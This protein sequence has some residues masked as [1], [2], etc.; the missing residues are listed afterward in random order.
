LKEPLKRRERALK[1]SD[2][3]SEMLMFLFEKIRKKKYILILSFLALI[4]I[5]YFEFKIPQIT[6]TIIDQSIPEKSFQ[7]I[8]INVTNLMVFALILSI[9]SYFSTMLMSK[10]SQEVIIDVRGDLYNQILK[11]DMSYFENAKTGDLMTRLSS[12]VKTIQDLIS[13]QSLKLISNIFTFF[14]ILLFMFKQDSKLTLLIMITFPMLYFLNVFFSKRIKLAYKKVRNSTSLVNNHLQTSLTSVLLI[15]TFTSENSE[16][17]KFKELNNQNKNDYLEA[18]KYQTVFSPAIDLV[19]Y[20]GLGIVLLYSGNQ[21][22]KG[23]QTIGNLVAYMAYL[24]MLQNPIRSFTQ[25][26]SRFQQAVVSYSRIIEIFDSEPKITTVK[27]SMQLEKFSSRIVFENVTFSYKNNINVL[28]KVNF[29]MKYGEVTAIVGISG[30][31]KSTITKLIERL[32]D[33]TDGKIL[34]DSHDI[35]KYSLKS[36]RN[37]IGLVSQ[38][39]ELIDGT[40]Y[41]NIIYG[42]PNKSDKEVIKA[43]E[44][45]NLVEFINNLP[46]GVETEVGEK[47][48]KLSGGQKQRI[49]I[50]RI[51]LKN[52]PVLI[53]DEATASLDNESERYI[54]ESLDQ[55][56]EKRTSIVIAHRLSTIQKADQILVLDQGMI[57]E[58]GTHEELLNK[59]KR[60]R[61]LYDAQFS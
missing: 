19:N 49:A 6:Q 56:L 28:N 29:D 31:G 48:I 16:G 47:G 44:A 26:V 15:K 7:L 46:K 36:L 52:A 57:V 1:K 3:I 11:Q 39:I 42:Q 27:D 53:L 2:T 5:S 60:Y 45:A 35:K 12:D 41:E 51:F 9:L 14:F 58:K 34:I 18:M 22:I 59:N 32:Y 37:N 30:S 61:K 54:Q 40:I 24:K 17:E 23:E 20:L 25:M 33:V 8:L 4:G 38:D 55:L 13:P 10:L 21:I 43:I 50:A